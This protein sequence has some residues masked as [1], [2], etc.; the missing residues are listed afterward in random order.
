MNDFFT[1]TKIAKQCGRFGK[2]I[3]A[4]SFAQSVKIAQSVHT[5]LDYLKNVWNMNFRIVLSVIADDV[6]TQL[7]I[8][9]VANVVK[10]VHKTQKMAHLIYSGILV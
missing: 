4:T 1:F 5:D 7:E 6:A 9:S 8:T 3:V 2:I 10:N